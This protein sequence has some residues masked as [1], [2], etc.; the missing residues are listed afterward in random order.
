[1]IGAA[2][3]PT[4]NIMW[5]VE[6]EAGNWWTLT[7]WEHTAYEA[8]LQ[9]GHDTVTYTMPIPSKSPDAIEG[10]VFFSYTIDLINKIQKNEST[11]TARRLM[12][13]VNP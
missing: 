7:G 13:I 5:M 6:I 1:M 12:R 8:A 2:G 4:S 9:Q 10:V 11:G 3:P